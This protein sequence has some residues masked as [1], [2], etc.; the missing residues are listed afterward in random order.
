MTTETHK[1][2]MGKLRLQRLE[3][4][5]A[6]EFAKQVQRHSVTPVVDDDYPE[7]RHDYERALSTLV[8]AMR[9]N[10]RPEVIGK[11]PAVALPKGNDLPENEDFHRWAM[12]VTDVAI[13]LGENQSVPM[14]TALYY[15]ICNNDANKF[16]YLS[17]VLQ[18]AFE[19]GQICE[20]EPLTFARFARENKRRCTSPDGFGQDDLE[21][22][23]VSMWFSALA[24]EAG[25]AIEPMLM[26]SLLHKINRTGDTVKKIS[27]HEMN[28]AGNDKSGHELYADFRKECGDIGVYLDLMCQAAGFSLEDAMIEVF[29]A[30]SEKIGYPVRLKCTPT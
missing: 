13:G 22:W 2:S 18:L 8:D 5:A 16:N 7:V 6:A 25:E 12:G 27:R 24:G 11:P 10:G 3:F 4:E 15:R 9:A 26:L 17:K 14:L 21:D 29:D 19:A 30:K 23:D 20:L 28:Y 1:A